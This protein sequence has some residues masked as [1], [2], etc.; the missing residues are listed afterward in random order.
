MTDW[1]S[2][3]VA[4]NIDTQWGWRVRHVKNFD[5]GKYVDIGYGTYI[6]A[7]YGVE[8]EDNVQIGSHVAIYSISTIDNKA[9]PVKICRNAKIG[10]HAVI[11]PGVTIG[12]NAK[13]GAFAF[14]IHNV[15]ENTTVVGQPAK[16]TTKSLMERMGMPYVR[17]KREDSLSSGEPGFDRAGGSV[18][19]PS[20]K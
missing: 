1:R 3:T 13:V 12:K 20:I 16:L 11:M 6:Q 9:G 19:A 2:P 17:F 18:K 14:V 15:E 7:E 10:S 8:I 5:I 4:D